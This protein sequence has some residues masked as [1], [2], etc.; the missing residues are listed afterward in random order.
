MEQT[1]RLLPLPSLPHGAKQV[2]KHYGILKEGVYIWRIYQFAYSC[3][4]LAILLSE[5]AT[6]SRLFGT[7]SDQNRTLEEIPRSVADSLPLIKPLRR[8]RTLCDQTQTQV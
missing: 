7:D 5:I 1:T 8:T 6:L 4:L 2:R 3:G